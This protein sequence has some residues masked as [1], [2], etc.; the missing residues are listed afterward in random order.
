MSEYS[1]DIVNPGH[2]S[3]PAA[4]TSV[5]II[6]IAFV[7]GAVFFVGGIPTGVLVAAI[8]AAVGVIVGIVMAKMGYGVHGPK[9]TPKPRH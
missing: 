1:E 8:I 9:F 7:I 4:W 2:G 5:T 3:S 6:L